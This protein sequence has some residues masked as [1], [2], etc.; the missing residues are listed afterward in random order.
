MGIS[1]IDDGRATRYERTKEADTT[2]AQHSVQRRHA[3]A[4]KPTQSHFGTET[5]RRA[6]L[7]GLSDYMSLRPILCDD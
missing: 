4:A 1:D 2:C 3:V 5:K 6:S 7:D